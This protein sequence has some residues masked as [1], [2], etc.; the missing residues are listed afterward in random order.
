M[1]SLTLYCVWL[2]KSTQ[3]EQLFFRLFQFQSFP[4]HPPFYLFA[5]LFTRLGYYP[6][7]DRKVVICGFFFIQ[8]EYHLN[9]GI[10]DSVDN[11]CSLPAHDLEKLQWF[12]PLHISD[13]KSPQLSCDNDTIGFFIAKLRKVSWTRGNTVYLVCIPSWI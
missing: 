8:G 1:N 12:H 9:H 11:Y 10:P 6:N 5:W 7:S 4:S 2:Y 3:M 13:L